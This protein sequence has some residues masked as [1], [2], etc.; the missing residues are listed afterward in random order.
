[1][2]ARDFS[3]H[4]CSGHEE[5]PARPK[6]YLVHWLNHQYPPIRWPWMR[7]VVAMQ[8]K[9]SVWFEHHTVALAFAIYAARC[10]QVMQDG[11]KQVNMRTAYAN[12]NED[13]TITVHGIQR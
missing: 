3:R 4:Y 8:G 1:M 11:A 6:P 13:G 7:W 10:P 9:K 5:P 2:N 12:L